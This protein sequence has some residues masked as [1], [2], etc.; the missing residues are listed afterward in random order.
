MNYTEN[1]KESLKNLKRMNKF[2]KVTGYKIHIQKLVVFLMMILPKAIYRFSGIPIKL[3]V[4]SFTEL[5]QKFSQ[6]VWKHNRLCVAK[7][8]LRKKNGAGRI[9]L[10]HFRLCYKVTVIKTVCIGTKTEI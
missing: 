5:E 4:A 10:S 8:V 2:S 3:P 7:A 9:N 1:T 6:F